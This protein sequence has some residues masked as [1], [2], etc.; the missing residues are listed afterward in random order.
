MA[1]ATKAATKKI[2]CFI[3]TYGSY[4]RGDVAGF[5]PTDA[6]ALVKKGIAVEGKKLPQTNAE[7]TES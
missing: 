5:N 6:E 1:T 3:K 4:V 7:E 2:V